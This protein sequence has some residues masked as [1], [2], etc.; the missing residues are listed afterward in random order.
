MKL[1]IEP[2]YMVQNGRDPEYVCQKIVGY[3]GKWR[4]PSMGCIS[5]VSLGS[6]QDICSANIYS[7]IFILLQTND[8][9]SILQSYRQ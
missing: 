1:L 7:Y 4:W 8:T 9:F 6:Y 2:D 5:N 3:V